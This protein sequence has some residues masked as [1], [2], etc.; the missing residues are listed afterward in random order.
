GWP[1]RREGVPA[2]A[3]FFRAG[4]SRPRASPAPGR[5]GVEPP[6][7]R[8][9]LLRGAPPA[10]PRVPARGRTIRG[11]LPDLRAGAPGAASPRRARLHPARRLRAQ[12]GPAPARS[13]GARRLDATLSPL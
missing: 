13:P 6:R 2:P 11:A 9:V 4:P 8:L 5:D 10:H 1:N 7:G 12:L 3:W